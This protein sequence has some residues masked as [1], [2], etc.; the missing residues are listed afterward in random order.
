MG[1]WM[2]GDLS[3]P[4]VFVTALLLAIAL[5][6]VVA[7]VATANSLE[8]EARYEVD[9]RLAFRA[10]T[11]SATT[12]VRVTNRT[13]KAVGRLTFNLATLAV[14]GVTLTEV[15]Q[16]GRP[17]IHSIDDQTITVTLP[18]VLAT[19]KSTTVRI[20]YGGVLRTDTVDKN[21][22]FSKVGGIVTAYRWIPWL[23]RQTAF[24]RPNFGTPLVTATSHSVKVRI[25]TDR[26][27]QLATSGRR[28]VATRLSHTFV[29]T[30]VRDFNF[31][32]SPH[33]AVTTGRAG[34]IQVRVLSIRQP[35]NL[36]REWAT[37]A[38]T[39]YGELVGPYPY[40]YFTVAE[41]P[42]G[43]SMES[44]AL[45][46]VGQHVKPEHL[47]LVVA[48]ETAHQWFYGVVGTDQADE[49][50]ADEAPTDFLARYLVGKRR[51]SRCGLA[52]LDLTVYDYVGRCY[53]EVIYIQGGNYLDDYRTR[54]GDER[55]WI[56]LRNYYRSHRF[57]LGGTRQLLDALDRA[58]GPDGGGHA[59]RFP[60]YYE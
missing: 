45:A 19:G 17:L 50:F 36:M 6:G 34:A 35:G 33:Y 14:A 42:K 26:A 12:S 2:G 10:G 46:W 20:G 40:A 8:L 27:L 43:A 29:A 38:L 57:K 15:T 22:Y 4:L 37:L 1:V 5:G 13:G 53:Y 44:P 60:R 11:L 28:T 30:N 51:A 39:R 9:A 23:S 18:T 59:G 16:G 3:R 24:A 56:G 52:R 58:A 7:P 32:A 49:P 47:P 55:F 48:H 21:W 41:A 54:V 31:S 25:R